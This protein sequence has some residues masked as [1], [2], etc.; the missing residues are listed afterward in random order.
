METSAVTVAAEI[1]A[2]TGRTRNPTAAVRALELLHRVVPSDASALQLVDG[3]STSIVAARGHA[4]AA[5][6][7]PARDFLRD[8]HLPWIMNSRLPLSLSTDRSS[9]FRE[10]S[11]FRRHLEPLGFRDG[12]SVHLVFGGETV[13]F[14]HL[15]AMR[16]S[17]GNAERTIAAAVEPALARWL[18]QEH[19]APLLELSDR[20]PRGSSAVVVDGTRTREVAGY[21]PPPFLGDPAFTRVLDNVRLD[22]GRRLTAWWPDRGQW[23]RFVVEPMHCD[24]RATG[25]AALL[26]HAL[27]EELPAGLT[28]R[29]VDVLTCLALGMD[30]AS[31]AGL[32]DIS[33]R[34][35]HSHVEAV[36]RR[37]GSASRLEAAAWAHREGVLHPLAQLPDA[38][39][40]RLSHRR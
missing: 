22:R 30:D 11:F 35:V 4:G 21:E 7:E 13:G 8:P 32:F 20:V 15:S 10:G 23:Y 28:R 12:M 2:L 16:E 9:S 36:R 1:G 25:G 29:E 33:L 6:E 14:L 5:D 17:F 27:P 39:V 3:A 19:R 18:H 31:I 34:T 24:D 38:G 26:V 37:T 40:G